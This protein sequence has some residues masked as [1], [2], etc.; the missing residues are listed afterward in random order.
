MWE[1]EKKRR[2]QECILPQENIKGSPDFLFNG[3]TTIAFIFDIFYL[4]KQDR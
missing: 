4:K 1:Q 2:K 3:P